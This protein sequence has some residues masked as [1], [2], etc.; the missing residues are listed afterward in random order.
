MEIEKRP[1][2]YRRVLVTR[3][4]H[5]CEALCRLIEQAGGIPLR[6]PALA[7]AA[8]ADPLQARRQLQQLEG[9]EIAVFISRNAVDK[10]IELLQPQALPVSV[11][12]LAIGQATA[13]ALRDHGYAVALMPDRDFRSEGLLAM[14][15]LQNVRG[16][17]IAI[18][19]GAGGRELLAEVLRERGA[20]IEYI[21]VY[22][23]IC[24]SEATGEL[25]DLL[26]KRPPELVIATST[27][28]LQNLLEMSGN[29]R[30]R[31]LP[32]PLVVLSARGRDFALAAGCA[33]V[34][35]APRSDD[36]GI[37]AALEQA[38][39]EGL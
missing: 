36:A 29:Y 1:L 25:R 2:L 4:A 8:P 12:C 23:A 19:R 13:D 20:D 7:I 33:R 17:R 35:I 31:L 15:E 14:P 6:L 10:A 26:A 24:P 37:V 22:R 27:L 9:C 11:K 5:Q 3:P 21:E 38:A 16:K 28:I 39:S 18:I 30:N 34:Y 32:R